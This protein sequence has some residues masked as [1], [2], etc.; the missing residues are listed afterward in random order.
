LFPAGC[1]FLGGFMIAKPRRSNIIQVILILTVLLWCI[2]GNAGDTTAQ[3]K[4]KKTTGH[5][6]EICSVTFSPD[7]KY[8]V[9]GSSDKTLILWDTATGKIIRKFTGHSGK[10]YSV[11]FSPDGK[12]I[13]SGSSD[14][15]LIVWNAATGKQTRK[16][17]G[18]SDEVVSAIFSPDGSRILS[19]SLDDTLRLW[20]VTAGRVITTFSG[21]ANP[22]NIAFS[23]DGK[24]FVSVTV[25]G[26]R[27]IE[28]RDTLSGKEVKSFPGLLYGT[29]SIRFSQDGK[30]IYAISAVIF[31][32]EWDVESG[33]RTKIL[34]R[35]HADD[36]D[37]DGFNISE[38]VDENAAELSPDGTLIISSSLDG[39]ST[40]DTTSM[41]KIR[42]V[43]A[44]TI[45]LDFVV[46]TF[47]PDGKH[48]V[49]GSRDATLKLWETESG[50]EI[51]LF[52]TH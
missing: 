32:E 34:K 45:D 46:L 10:V 23:P 48:F 16:F 39:I 15:M 43:K 52:G 35:P 5:S 38:R 49:S 30:R 24:F 1:V 22:R 31:L 3:S 29:R 11:A 9:S 36:K 13:V 41:E 21:N 7:G 51:R 6:D 19:G 44:H 8:I 20:N 28:M 27:T 47:S 4:V 12:Y 18:H 17:T 42:I 37:S 25:K 33:V 14:K 2:M 50:K 40:W 26:E